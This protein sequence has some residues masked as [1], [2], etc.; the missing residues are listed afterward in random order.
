[1]TLQRETKKPSD[2]HGNTS[3][4][5]STAPSSS[6]QNQ[7]ITLN[8]NWSH[9]ATL[10]NNCRQKCIRSIDLF[11]DSS[12]TAI[13]VTANGHGAHDHAS[14][15][16]PSNGEN[17][18][19]DGGGNAS[20]TSRLVLRCLHFA[21]HVSLPTLARLNLILVSNSRLTADRLTA[22]SA[23]FFF[24][25][26]HLPCRSWSLCSLACS[27]ILPGAF[28]LLATTSFQGIFSC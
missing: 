5:K 8:A 16:D 22:K 19:G 13:N 17:G 26:S 12:A 14:E 2:L 9:W 3:L 4:H 6:S 15:M 27:L 10:M 7:N 18:S 11:S 25:R 21:L 24:C 1:M 20:R 28:P 23:S